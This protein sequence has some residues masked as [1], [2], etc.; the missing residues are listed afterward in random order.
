MPHGTF[1]RFSKTIS[2]Y[3]WENFW[4]RTKVYPEKRQS[5]QE[6]LY[7]TVGVWAE[8]AICWFLVNLIAMPH[9]QAISLLG[10]YLWQTLVYS[11][12]SLPLPPLPYC[13]TDTR[14]SHGT[15]FSERNG[16]RSV[17]SLR[18]GSLL[19]PLPQSLATCQTE[20]ALLAS[21]W[22]WKQHGGAPTTNTNHTAWSVK[23]DQNKGLYRCLWRDGER[24]KNIGYK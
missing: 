19:L 21:A 14:L 17:K 23:A 1:V 11:K 8:E 16:S 6:F 18:H 22:E 13:S 7:T 15:C 20:A 2:I 10:I 3:I 12:C 9:N 5:P 24:K 4:N